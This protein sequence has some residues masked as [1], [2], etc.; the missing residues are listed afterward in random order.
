M[1]AVKSQKA[2]REV[3]HADYA[4]VHVCVGGNSRDDAN[5]FVLAGQQGSHCIFSESNVTIT[6]HQVRIATR[7]S[8]DQISHEQL[9]NPSHHNGHR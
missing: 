6:W 2:L 8:L 3:A 4:W 1:G 7:T 5:I 9:S